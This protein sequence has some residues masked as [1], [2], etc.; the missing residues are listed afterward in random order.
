LHSKVALNTLFL[1][2][3][4]TIYNL[5]YEAVLEIIKNIT[6]FYIILQ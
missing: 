3:Y 5:L 1:L 6:F 2:N 4:R